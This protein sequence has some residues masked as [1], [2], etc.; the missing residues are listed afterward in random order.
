MASELI[1]R[2]NML[3]ETSDNADP[4][5][6]SSSEGLSWT[7]S[8]FIE[9][10]KSASWFIALFFI[11]AGLAIA[12]FFIGDIVA[13]G[14]I[15]IAAIL[16]GIIAN[17]KPRELTYVIN[18]TGI[19]VGNKRFPH[20]AFKS[21]SLVQEGGIQSIWLMPSKRFDPGLSIYFAPQEGQ[22]IVNYLGTLIPYEERKP[23][24]I[25]RFMHNI[26]F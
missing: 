14:M 24:P 25:D 19:T 9:H 20:S 26:R 16:F 3:M 11:T 13:S 21:F 18:N 2:Y 12:A 5:Q 22:K 7:A 4:M 15:V 6:Q 17:R 23:D 10:T 8:E 1:F